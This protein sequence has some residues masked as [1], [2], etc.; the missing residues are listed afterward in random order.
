M[1]KKLRKLIDLKIKEFIKIILDIRQNGYEND[2]IYSHRNIGYDH[3]SG[4]GKHG[5]I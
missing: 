2:L 1:D 4:T 3:L 5:W